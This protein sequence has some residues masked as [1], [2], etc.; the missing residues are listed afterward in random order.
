MLDI[1]T[2]NRN[3][4]EQ[5]DMMIR[6]LRTVAL[7][8]KELTAKELCSEMADQLEAKKTDN[9][10]PDVKALIKQWN[11]YIEA[12]MT[13]PEA[14]MR[15]EFIHDQEQK[16]QYERQVHREKVA[17]EIDRQ[18]AFR[19]PPEEKVKI[20]NTGMHKRTTIARP[21]APPII[22]PKRP[23]INEVKW[24]VTDPITGIQT[25]KSPE[26]WQHEYDALMDNWRIRCNQMQEQDDKNFRE[27]YMP[28]VNFGQREDAGVAGVPNPN[29][30]LGMQNASNP[31]RNWEDPNQ[32]RDSLGR[33]YEATTEADDLS[34][35]I[36]D[37]VNPNVFPIPNTFIGHKKNNIIRREDGSKLA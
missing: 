32:H 14:I 4:N 25:D 35:N 34:R 36:T 29:S 15:E 27:S 10:D 11:N 17:W 37:Y 13:E 28:I 5:A 1:V 18:G 16:K 21:S 30:H 20:G 19:L 22:L 7:D 31:C 24:K 26:V 2:Q 12:T 8:P 33:T 23:D 9:K 3:Q 6:M